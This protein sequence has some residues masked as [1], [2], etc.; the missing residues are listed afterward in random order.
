[1]NLKRLLQLGLCLLLLPLSAQ[2]QGPYVDNEALAGR[3]ANSLERQVPAQYTTLAISRVKQEN[4]Q[5]NFNVNELIDYANVKIVRTQRF[6][7]TDR[8]KLQLILKEQRIQLSELVSPND[9][10]ELGRLLGVQLFVYGSIYSDSL[11]LKAI[12]VQT[13]SIVWADAFPLFDDRNRYLMM[14][15]L[16]GKLV[17][18]LSRDKTR[19]DEERIRRVSFWSIDVP[20]PLISEEVMDYLTVAFS[21]ES[22]MSVVDRENLK[23]I[24]QEQ[25]LNQNVFID[26]GEARRLGELYGVDAFIYGS[27]ST[28]PDGELVASLKMMSIYTGVIVWADLI[29]FGVPLEEK[30]VALINPFTKKIQQRKPEDAKD[31]VLIPGGVFVM[32]SNDPLYGGSE[33]ERTV[34]VKSFLIDTHEVTNDQYYEFVQRTGH[35][36]PVGWTDGRYPDGQADFPVVGVT[37]EDAK[38]YCQYAGKRLLMEVEWE[39]AIRGEKG[40]KYPWN[41][42]GFAPSFSVTRESGSETPV[43][44]YQN[45]RDVTPEGVYHLSG[46]VREYV[47]DFYRPY[48]TGSS[49]AGGVERVVRGGSWAFSAFEAAGYH[50]GKSRPNLA[51]P[52]TGIRCGKTL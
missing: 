42:T 6:R 26:E 14:N 5:L 11:V 32:G 21:Q 46:N 44:V 50:R 20:Q 39:R 9:Y 3:I 8:S 43:S 41:G 35:R 45:N 10:K 40:R 18:S 34:R 38:L 52:D 51:W 7:V 49:D 15:D 28:R 24:Y 29:K 37:W 1:M 33:P 31:Q 16:N 25:K 12:D 30:K 48:A 36:I 27:V 47:A 17:D 23:L 22:L 19:L 4:K 13:S 2:A